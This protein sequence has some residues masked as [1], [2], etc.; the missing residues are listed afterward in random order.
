[1]HSRTHSMHSMHQ[2][3]LH[4]LASDKAVPFKFCKE[5]PHSSAQA[6]VEAKGSLGA[7]ICGSEP[8]PLMVAMHRTHSIPFHALL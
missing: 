8:V 2:L 1:M 6:I 7:L 3:A 4:H 5:P